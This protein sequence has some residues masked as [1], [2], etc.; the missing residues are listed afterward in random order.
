[1]ITNENRKKKK[2]FKLALKAKNFFRWE[3]KYQKE[4]VFMCKSK[5]AG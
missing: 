5:P 3:E 2:Q 4:Q 1:L